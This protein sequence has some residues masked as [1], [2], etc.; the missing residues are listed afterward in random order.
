M[1]LD[2]KIKITAFSFD[3]YGIEGRAQDPILRVVLIFD[4][5]GITRTASQYS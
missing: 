5:D 2:E 3:E 1:I 4:K